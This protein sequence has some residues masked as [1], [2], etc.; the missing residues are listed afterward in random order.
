MNPQ[1][2]LSIGEFFAKC[3]VD[4]SFLNST[5]NLMWEFSFGDPCSVVRSW[6]YHFFFSF[7]KTQDVYYLHLVV[8]SQRFYCQETHFKDG[9]KSLTQTVLFASHK[10]STIIFLTKS[11]LG[12]ASWQIILFLEACLSFKVGTALLDLQSFEEIAWLLH[13]S[14]GEVSHSLFS[15]QFLSDLSPWKIL[16]FNKFK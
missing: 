10:W 12:S 6:P 14:F 3:S 9:V 5:K 16:P 1:Q 7:E 2:K 8:A 15:H 4:Y 13:H 11:T